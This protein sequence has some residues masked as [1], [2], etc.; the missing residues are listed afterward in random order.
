MPSKRE[1][2]FEEK[3]RR[4][5][6]ARQATDRFCK[7][8]ATLSALTPCDPPQDC[9]VPLMADGCF[10]AALEANELPF[11]EFDMLEAFGS[12]EAAREAEETFK[13]ELTEQI[14]L[15]DKGNKISAAVFRMGFTRESVFEYCK[16]FNDPE[17]TD[18]LWQAWHELM[19]ACRA[20][21]E[22]DW[23]PEEE[24]ELTPEELEAIEKELAELIGPV[25]D[26]D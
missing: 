8:P 19:T 3:R 15:N 13:E 9:L 7:T 12:E 4:G 16:G 25:D 6:I 17:S 23:P 14:G 10:R 2:W 26:D 21:G 18:P 20:F 5:E 22:M 11:I 1:A 24:R